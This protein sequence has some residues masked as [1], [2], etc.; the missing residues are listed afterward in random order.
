MA[1][2]ERGKSRQEMHEVIKE[3]SIAAGKKVKEEGG[4]NDLLHRLAG[5]DAMPFTLE[6]LESLISDYNAFTGRASQQVEEY[7][8]EVVT[9][10]LQSNS[11][12]MS[13]IDAS[14]SV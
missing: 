14:L 5:D 13:Q 4:E 8:E 10:L 1:A 6:E 3:H 11:D 12:R 7:L 2:V 9:P